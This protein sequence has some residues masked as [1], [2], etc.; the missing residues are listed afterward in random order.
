MPKAI[1]QYIFQDLKNSIEN[2]T[3]EFQELLPSEN[4]LVET[5]SCSRNTVR[6]AIQMLAQ[7]GYVQSMH[8]VGVRVIYQP[9]KQNLF[10]IG[11]IE[12]YK[13]T[14]QRNGLHPVTKVVQFAELTVDKRIARTTGFEEGELIY[15]IQRLRYVDEMAL[16]LDIN[17]FLKE[18]VPGL[19]KEI[20]ENS[21]YEYIENTLGMAI[22]TSKRLMTVE[23]VTQVDEKYMDLGDYNCL[24]VVSSQTYNSDGVMFE[25]TQS[26]HRP[27]YFSFQNTATRQ[28]GFSNI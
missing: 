16:I 2:Q 23:K 20:A 25:Y 4:V 27:D 18:A 21:I 12:T 24:A 3:F 13:E 9:V 8:G 10:S 11:G 19:T 1:F 26:R 17:M 22:I 6:R 7:I 28:K 14:A 15:Y 5:Y